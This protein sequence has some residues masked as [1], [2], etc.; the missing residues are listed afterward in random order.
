M[1]PYR[2]CLFDMRTSEKPNV[3]YSFDSFRN[4]EYGIEQYQNVHDGHTE[5]DPEEAKQFDQIPS[6]QCRGNGRHVYKKVG[7]YKA[8]ATL[9]LRERI[10]K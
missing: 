7:H 9:F 1:L 2:D 8:E 10:I 3:W 5:E 6:A 4:Q